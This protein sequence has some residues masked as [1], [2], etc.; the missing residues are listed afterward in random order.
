MSKI[1]VAAGHTTSLDTTKRGTWIIH[2]CEIIQTISNAK[3]T[4]STVHDRPSNSVSDSLDLGQNWVRSYKPNLLTNTQWTYWTSLSTICQVILRCKKVLLVT[5]SVFLIFV[6]VKLTGQNLSVLHST[7][8][9]L[10]PDKNAI[11][12][13]NAVGINPLLWVYW[14]FHITI[15]GCSSN[16]FSRHICSDNLHTF[17]I[18]LWYLAH[19]TAIF[20]FEV[21]SWTEVWF[22]LKYNRH[23]R[24]D[25]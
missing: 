3:W 10:I 15:L 2:M 7:K 24:S 14:I 23:N 4:T 8:T 5:A 13:S 6:F 11:D 22:N 16:G 20:V 9:H 17:F 12:F 25:L 21:L 19:F 1:C 18:M